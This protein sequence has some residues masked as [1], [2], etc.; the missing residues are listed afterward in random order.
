VLQHSDCGSQYRSEQFQ[1]LLAE[2]GVTC[3]MSQ[4]GKVWTKA[5]MESCFFLRRI[6][7]S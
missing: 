5:A 4:S 6:Q 3:S 1:R 7:H 2:L